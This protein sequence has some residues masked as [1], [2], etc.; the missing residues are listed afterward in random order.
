MIEP[1][2]PELVIKHFEFL[3][4][5]FDFQR[6]KLYKKDKG[7]FVKYY[8]ANRGIIFDWDWREFF[9]TIL[10]C[11]LAP[12]PNKVKS[13]YKIN[14]QEVIENFSFHFLVHLKNPSAVIPTDSGTTD[15]EFDV[16]IHSHAKLL[17]EYCAD[18]LS[19]DDSMLPELR[20]QV[21]KRIKELDQ[22]MLEIDKKIKHE[23]DE[24]RKKKSKL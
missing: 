8:R 23:L 10:L 15:K 7:L 24:E 11:K 21:N 9:V 19:G 14:R 5:E 1:L 16:Y 17:K 2:F 6:E 3:E 18:F 12:K 20:K 22:E 4:S 13:W